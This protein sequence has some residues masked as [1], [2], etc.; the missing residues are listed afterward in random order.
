MNNARVAPV[1]RP[2]PMASSPVPPSTPRGAKHGP[3]QRTYLRRPRPMSSSPVPPSTPEAPSM[4]Q[5]NGPAWEAVGIGGVAAADSGL[6]LTDR[7]EHLAWP[8]RQKKNKID[9]WKKNRLTKCPSVCR[10]LIREFMEQ[11]TADRL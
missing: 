11:T 8:V 2:H 5:C 3:V 1:H 6:C 10:W 9:H 7:T 4:A